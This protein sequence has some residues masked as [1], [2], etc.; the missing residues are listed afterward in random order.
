[1]KQAYDITMLSVCPPFQRLKQLINFK[2]TWYEHYA[3]DVRLNF[4][5]FNLPQLVITWLICRHVS[6]K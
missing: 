2:K 3:I 6:W 1:M 4:I 5:P